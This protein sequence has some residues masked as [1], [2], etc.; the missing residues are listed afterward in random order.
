MIY[1]ELGRNVWESG[2]LNILGQDAPFYSL[3]HPAL[4]GLPLALFDTSFGYDVARVLQALVMSLVAVPVFLW[5]RRLMSETWALAA[6]AL[7]LSIPGLAYSGLL[8]TETVFLP[9]VTLAA[10]AMWRVLVAPTP[11]AQA[12]LLGAIALAVLT[13]LQGL[14]L[15]PVFVLAV[16]LYAGSLR[17]WTPVRRLA[18]AL[19]ALAALAI[20]WLLLGGFGAYGPAGEAGYDVAD[21]LRFIA[22]HAAD[23]LLLVAVVPACALVQLFIQ[24]RKLEPPV[25]AYLAVAIAL[26]LGL[27]AEVGI[28][29]SRYVGRLA[30]RDLLGLVPVLFLGLALWLDHGAPRTRLS[31]SLIALGAVA[32]VL[33]LPLGRLVHKAA[34]PDAF[35]LVPVWELGSYEAVVWGF[36]G[37]A[38]LA[39]ALLPRRALV[40]LPVALALVFGVTSVQ[41]SR[42][43][44]KEAAGLKEAFFAGDPEWIDNTASGNVAYFYDGEPHWNAVWEYVFWNRKLR[45]VYWLNGTRRVPGP[46]PQQRVAPAADGTLAPDAPPFLLASTAF[47]FFGAPVASIAQTGLVQKGLVLW[48]VEPPLRLSTVRTGV[49]GSGDIYGPAGMT[50]YACTGGSF[51][52]TLVAKGAPVTVVLQSG[53]NRVERTLA[54]EEVWSPSVPGA[55]VDGR[56]TLDL[57]PSGIVGSTRFEFARS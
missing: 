10:W 16:L 26:T 20:L 38:A 25:G 56:C 46:L 15:V 22:Y 24:H 45:H 32:V 28:F 39:F 36:A 7:T 55:P 4:V 5:G 37:A 42:F 21:S 19:G 13:R 2:H 54:P 33:V 44:A 18:P 29:A 6:A 41:A 9:A 34:L 35:M 40:A 14:V 43:E 31:S 49:Q 8:M 51:A 48:Q 50:A 1:A 17:S 47:T 57:T 27:V 23:A 11:R 30:E 3:A 12:L 53:A 52:L